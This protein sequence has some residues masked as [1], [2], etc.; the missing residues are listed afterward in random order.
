MKIG[1]LE[2]RLECG[3]DIFMGIAQQSIGKLA[4]IVFEALRQFD[5][6]PHEV[7]FASKVQMQVGC[8]AV[9]AKQ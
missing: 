7:N 9:G 1:C 8:A 6:L 3:Q 2:T 4:L 5:L